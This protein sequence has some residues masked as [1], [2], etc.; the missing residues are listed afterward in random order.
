MKYVSVIVRLFVVGFAAM[1]VAGLFACEPRTD[2]PPLNEIEAVDTPP[3][4]PDTGAIAFFLGADRVDDGAGRVL[5]RTVEGHRGVS[6]QDGRIV[7]GVGE[8]F[9]LN[10]L[11]VKRRYGDAW[12]AVSGT[13]EGV[14]VVPHR[15]QA[16]T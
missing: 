7:L 1:F 14:Y 13:C 5:V 12:V 2:P 10:V 8:S 4:P 11:C 6:V 16:G 15:P 9:D 3:A